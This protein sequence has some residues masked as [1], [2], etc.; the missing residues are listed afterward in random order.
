MNGVTAEPLNYR[1]A[2]LCN[3]LKVKIPAIIASC[4]R[5]KRQTSMEDFEVGAEQLLPWMGVND[6]QG[7]SICTMLIQLALSRVSTY[8]QVAIKTVFPESMHSANARQQCGM[9]S[10]R[11]S[12]VK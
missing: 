3:S 12:R 6:P 11:L 10:L 5:C 4:I 9:L 8:T 2:P 7:R 1:L